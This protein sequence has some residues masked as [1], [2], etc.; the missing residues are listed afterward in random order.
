MNKSTKALGDIA[1]PPGLAILA[2]AD[3]INAGLSLLAHDVR[4]FLT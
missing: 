3:H 2:V 1:N 4:H